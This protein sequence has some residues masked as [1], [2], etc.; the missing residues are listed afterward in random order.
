MEPRDDLTIFDK[1]A[2]KEGTKTKEKPRKAQ[3]LEP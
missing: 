1:D 3:P 2:Q